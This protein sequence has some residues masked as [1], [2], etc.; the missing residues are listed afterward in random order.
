MVS[1]FCKKERLVVGYQKGHLNGQVLVHEPDTKFYGENGGS[2]SYVSARFR[3][4][5]LS[6]MHARDIVVVHKRHDFWTA[7][8]SRKCVSPPSGKGP[9]SVSTT[10]M[11]DAFV[12]SLSG[13][14]YNG[15]CIKRPGLVPLC[16]F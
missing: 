13:N 12:R 9:G 16:T 10:S 5:L 15:N 2:E 4:P 6:D 1:F 14:E 11:K 7:K 3:H 8:F